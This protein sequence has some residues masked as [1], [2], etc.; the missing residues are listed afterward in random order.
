M[1]VGASTTG[2][3]GGVWDDDV[4]SVMNV[5]ASITDVEGGVWDDDVA[6]VEALDATVL[7]TVKPFGSVTP[8]LV[9]QV[10]GS[11]P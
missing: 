7:P 5:G 6:G 3:E 1:N 11:S 4:A 8:W 10:L 2:V 9:A